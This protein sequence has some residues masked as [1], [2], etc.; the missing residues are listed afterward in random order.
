MDLDASATASPELIACPQ[1]E[2]LAP[3]QVLDRFTLASTDGPVEHV[4][5][6][7]LAGHG[8]TPTAETVAAWPVA[9]APRALGA[10]G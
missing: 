1:P 5:T 4:K 9:P 2:C 10:S 3:A 7:C 6:M 8:F